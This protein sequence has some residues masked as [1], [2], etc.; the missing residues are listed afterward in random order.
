[1]AIGYHRSA[2]SFVVVAAVSPDSVEAAVARLR[3]ELK[4]FAAAPVSEA[5][6]ARHARALRN[7]VPLQHETPGQ[8]IGNW[9]LARLYGLPEDQAART[10]EEIGRLTSAEVGA[11][12]ARWLDAERAQIVVVGPAK[13]IRP[14]LERLGAATVV[15]ADAPT[16]TVP[17]RAAATTEAPSEAQLAQGRAVVEKSVVAHGGSS[18]L[19]GIKDSTLEGEAVLLSGGKE[20]VGTLRQVRKEPYRMLYQTNFFTNETYQVLNGDHG[21]M[22][23]SGTAAPS[24][25]ELDS[26]EVQ[27]LRF[28]YASDLPHLLLTAADPKSRVAW[29]G[30]EPIGGRDADVIEV[31]SVE[32]QRFV[33]FIDAD[34]Q[35][36]IGIEQN[37]AGAGQGWVARRLFRDFRPVNGILWPHYEERQQNGQRIMRLTVRKVAL[38]TGVK[39]SLF[40]LK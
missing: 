29:R 1:S 6:I 10:A 7:A 11:A 35:R 18:K 16:I 12:T 28:A 37:Q 4:R 14:Q 25:A 34:N 30:R 13:R 24:Q 33:L 20:L 26:A 21:W 39:D 17:P 3:G 8:V 19:R 5:E 27:A 9:L 2:G 31:V 22:R 15:A 32:I 38:N 36:V 40:E 23:M